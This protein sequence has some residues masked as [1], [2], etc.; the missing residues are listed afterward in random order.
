[1]A[2]KAMRVGLLAVGSER[3]L[4]GVYYIENLIRA[5]RALPDDRQPAIVLIVPRAADAAAYGDVAGLVERVATLEPSP[6]SSVLAAGVGWGRKVGRVGVR[7]ASAASG[8]LIGRAV[9]PALD[10]AHRPLLDLLKRERLS[11][12]FPCTHPMGSDWPVPWLAWAWDLQHR[13]YPDYFRDEDRRWRDHVFATLAG[14]A[15][16]IVLS[17]RAAQ[18]DFNRFYP[19]ADRKL[20]VLSFATVPRPEWYGGRPDDTAARYG[21]PPRYFMVANQ[22]WVH[23]NHGIVFEAMARLNERSIHVQVVCTGH[24][25]DHRRPGYFEELMGYVREHRLTDQVR[26]VGVVPRTDQ[27]QLMRRAAAVIQP[28]LFEGWSSVVEDARTLGKRI[29]LSDIPVHREQA[30]SRSVYF[31]PHNPDALADLLATEWEAADSAP[32]PP[33]S[34]DEHTALA[35]QRGRVADY[36]RRFM[37][38]AAELGALWET[39]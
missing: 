3:W 11:L 29:V 25:D 34:D 7:I 33:S 30:P 12:L 17:S 18:Q 5:L 10:D 38:I 35:A 31:D 19:G 16:L 15:P 8:R 4:G 21:L 37:E 1:M 32:L 6:G 22:F 39:R 13:H 24:H 9:P 2:G 26:I 36:G 20:R 23:K 28:S 14:Q 27:I